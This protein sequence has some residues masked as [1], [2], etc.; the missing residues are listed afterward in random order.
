VLATLISVIL[1]KSPI[2]I[3][4]NFL[5]KKE[6]NKVLLRKGDENKKKQVSHK[7]EA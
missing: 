5:N 7:K 1:Q 3:S 2:I 4:L 6:R